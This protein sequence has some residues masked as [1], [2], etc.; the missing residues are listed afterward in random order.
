MDDHA[1]AIDI[2]DLERG[3]LGA[4]GTGRIECH[5][6][7]ALKGCPGRFDQM[8]DF[9]PAEHLRQAWICRGYGVSAALQPRFN[10]WI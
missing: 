10:T 2:A 3:Y 5:E 6:H 8:R 4:A 7:G 9:F 1:P